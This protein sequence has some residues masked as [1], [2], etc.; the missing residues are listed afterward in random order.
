MKQ[1]MD[2]ILE[3]GFE[4][5]ETHPE[6]FLKAYKVPSYND[7]PTIFQYNILFKD[8]DEEGS[9]PAVATG[10]S[11]TQT[12]ALK[13]AF[14]EMIERYSL[15]AIE[16]DIL[17]K[18]SYAQDSR[19]LNPRK[20]ISFSPELLKNMGVGRR[21]L[22][23]SKYTWVKCND[24]QTN[25]SY[26]IPAQLVYVPYK[27]RSEEFT[28]QAS[29]SSGAACGMSLEDAIYRGICEL[30]ER[31]SFLISYLNKLDCNRIDLD[32][33]KDKQ[34]QDM[35]RRITRY[36]LEVHL[37]I[38][39]KDVPVFSICAIV[40]DRTG[41]G[42]AVSVGL[43]AGFD[44]KE[45]I[46]GSLEEALMTRSWTRDDYTKNQK[47]KFPSIGDIRKIEDRAYY[48]FSTKMIKNLDFWLKS[49]N[50][51]SLDLNPGKHSDHNDN[52]KKLLE[53]FKKK[54]IECYFVMITS[55]MFNKYPVYVVKTIAPTLLSMYLD[56][57]YPNIYNTRLKKYGKLPINSIPHPFL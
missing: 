41:I 14:G 19:M 3:I 48:W 32:S 49:G 27:Y 47:Q 57:R 5:L 28:L 33:I 10:T 55:K 30:I 36:N 16:Q 7:E 35:L 43:R 25:K 26:L 9:H 54:K 50:F 56:E 52:F 2:N 12:I 22:E 18:K 21:K 8:K 17:R 42:P 39:T 31:D 15:S 53:I 11:F 34:I 45:V 6:V 46:I 40:L 4:L 37:I 13:K 38:T 44:K 24:V 29:N 1:Q 20:F 23:E 51:I